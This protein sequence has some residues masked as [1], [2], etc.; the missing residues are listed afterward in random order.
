MLG[1][2]INVGAVV[3]GWLAGSLVGRRVP[4]RYHRLVTAAIGL[5]TLVLGVR[6]AVR[7]EDLLLLLLAVL[8]GGLLGTALRI[9]ERLRS[10][11]GA[12][13][14][15][16]PRLSRGS[17]SEAFVTASL[18]YCVGPMTIL[19]ALRDG[20]YGDW[21]LLGLKAIMDGI[22]S[23]VLTA[24]LGPGVVFS[25]FVV[26]IYQG[27][28]SLAARWLVGGAPLTAFE[29]SP[30][31]REVDAAGGL[32]LIALA[33]RLLELRDLRAGNFLPALGVAPLL[34]FIA[35]IWGR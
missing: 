18:L 2:W 10:F 5:V 14:R 11:G 27:S 6:L 3:L 19:G 13:K 4:E 7:T 12:L 22:S 20:I 8:I 30:I 17:V 25:A 35:A 9:E 21:S 1:T 34:A 29:A 16:F 32:I 23:I 26:L 15:R 28:I 31:L 24:G 33:L